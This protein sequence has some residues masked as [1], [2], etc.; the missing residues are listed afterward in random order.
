MKLTILTGVA[1]VFT[2]SACA[3]YEVADT[4][5]P[6]PQTALAPLEAWPADLQGQ[7]LE[8]YTEN[9]WANAVNLAPEGK[10][11]IVPELGDK[12]V[13][14]T[15]MADGEALCTDYAPRGKECWP[16]KAVLAASEALAAGAARAIVAKLT[17]AKVDDKAARKAVAGALSRA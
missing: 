17:G 7:T 9:G 6:I 8:V 14:G 12:V 2:L 16:Y 5:E 1:A 4:G 10:L 15:W 11:S 3:T 13:V